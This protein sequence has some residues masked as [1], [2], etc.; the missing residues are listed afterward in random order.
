RARQQSRLLGWAFALT[1][2]AVILTLNLVVLT[3]LRVY[4]ASGRDGEPFGASLTEWSFA[5]PGTVLVTSLL[6]GG[7]IGVASLTRMLQLREGGGYVARAVGGV[8]VE[9]GT[10]DPKRRMLSN[11]VDEMALASGIPAP[12]IYVLEQEDSINAF[13]AGH[14]P[15][16]AA[17]A[18]TR[19]ALLK[20]N[21][22]QLQGVIAHEFSHVLNGDIRISIR[23]MGLVFGL[24][25]VS[26]AGRTLIRLA[27]HGDR[28]AGPILMLGLGIAAIGQ[29]GFWGGR[30]LQAWISRQRECLAD[31]AAVQ[32]TRNPDG[33]RDALVRAAALGGSRRFANAAMEQVAHM[34]FVSGSPRLLA[35]HPP[36][37][38]RLQALDPNL[39]Q[40]QL[41]SMLRRAQAQWRDSAAGQPAA[42]PD[43]ATEPALPDLPE[44]A[45]RG[46]PASAER[47]A[48]TTGLPGPQH[49]AFAVALRRAL[50]DSL[51]ASAAAPEQA[52]ALLLALVASE[53][54][55]LRQ[56]QLQ[57]VSKRL[58]AGEADTVRALAG[59]ARALQPL[60]RLPA[61]LQLFAALRALPAAERLSLSA[62]LHDMLTCDGKL[63]VF[64]YS[65]EKLALR[66]LNPRAAV[67]PP[68][69]G[70]GIGDRVEPLGVVFSV[71]ARQGARGDGEA[72][73][74]YEAGL[75]PL[76]PRIRPAYH[77]ID[78][79]VPAFDTALDSLQ[80]LQ[81]TAKQMVIEALVRTIAHD[82]WLAPEEAELLR[83]IC[84][85]LECPLPPV[86]PE[87]A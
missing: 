43:A 48:A 15:A 68:H 56:Q 46:V 72:R 6:V 71:L 74:A 37:L 63:S 51:R 41:E 36:L 3:L 82:N 49:L 17:V 1:L 30:L 21:R 70:F 7:F 62:L 59:R 33:L 11:I 79:W 23:L 67:A 13:A 45:P 54:A 38:Q 69:G 57:L 32:F 86:L 19:G 65:L 81:A 31:A 26:L 39:N 55:G 60:H 29:I 14:T 73:R 80:S 42:Q 34:L 22:D 4:Y 16:N 53:D 40:A 27:S 75:A 5:H 78:D 83:A 2:L 9:R 35:T 18:V 85:V 44:S 20:L 28:R 77:V 25:A 66:A 52:R 10:P 87:A 12:E 50:P 61:V 58:G 24:M 8:R 47:I 84:G 64:E 76:L